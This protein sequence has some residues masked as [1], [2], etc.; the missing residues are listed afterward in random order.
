MIKSKKVKKVLDIFN[1]SFLS[2]FVERGHNFFI[3]FSFKGG[4]LK[5]KE[6][7]VLETKIIYLS[8]CIIT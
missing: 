1:S 5:K 8:F 6:N 2:N 4:I 3:F 7:S